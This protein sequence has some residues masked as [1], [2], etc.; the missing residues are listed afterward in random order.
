MDRRNFLRAAV[1]LTGVSRACRSGAD[2]GTA[3]QVMTVREPVA[4]KS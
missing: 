2:D 1:A 3:A 4:R